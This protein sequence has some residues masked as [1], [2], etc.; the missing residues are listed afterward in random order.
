MLSVGQT[1][2]DFSLPGVRHGVARLFELFRPIDDG[3]SVVLCVYPSAFTPPAVAEL[4]ALDAAGWET[5]SDAVVWCLTGDSV[6]ANAA[7]GD[8][9]DVP[10]AMLSDFHAG[11]ADAYGVCLD[12][13]E[14][15]GPAPG[16]AYFLVDPDWTVRYARSVDDPFASPDPS[17]V[18]S[19]AEAL[20]SLVDD[21]GLASD[22]V[23]V[24]YDRY[25]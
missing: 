17:P 16:R 11:V 9:Y 4:R 7:F 14:A 12:D 21:Q 23:S 25:A 5:S 2:P 22:T 1:A 13:W 19:L 15:H 24:E 10:F 3:R 6:Y 8:R 18:I 20:A